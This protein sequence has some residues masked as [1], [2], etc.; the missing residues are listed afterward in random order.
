[1]ISLSGASAD[2][3]WLAARDE[4]LSGG[5]A[6]VEGRGSS[7]KELR[8]VVFELTDPRARW[9]FSRS[10][11]L[12]PAAFLSEVIWILSGRND[13]EFV[14]FCNPR[15]REFAG[16]GE[17]YSGAYGYRLRRGFGVDQLERAAEALSHKPESRQICLSIWDPR[18][19]MPVVKGTP[20]SPDIPCNVTSMLKIRDG[21]LEW[22]QIMRSN[23]LWLGLPLNIVQFT[24]LQE[25]MA[26][27]IGIDVGSYHHLSDSLH[28]YPRD[29][30]AL[31]KLAPAETCLNT[32]DFTG[33]DRAHCEALVADIAERLDTVIGSEPEDI[34]WSKLAPPDDWPSAYAN[35]LRVV[36]ADAA[37]RKGNASAATES[38]SQCTNAALVLL[39][40]RWLKRLAA[41]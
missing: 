2:Q 17:T 22:T 8:P 1:M 13:S 21:K 34:H 12:N 40:D 27:W 10:P 19:D 24:M 33:I 37:R 9:V 6:E 41:S 32:D 18:Q 4:F 20:R 7:T 38:M 25:I 11:V 3:L 39:W 5:A 29:E 36:L 15:L 31:R 30:D 14:N 26:G 16:D 23:D 35:L 28:L